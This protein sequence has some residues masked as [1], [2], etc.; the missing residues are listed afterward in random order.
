M[1]WLFGSAAACAHAKLWYPPKVP[2]HSYALRVRARNTVGESGFPSDADATSVFRAAA[3]AP[4]PPIVS[5]ATGL[6]SSAV[7]VH[8]S[9]EG[10][11]CHGEHPSKFRIECGEGEVDMVAGTSMGITFN[12]VGNLCVD[13][14]CVRLP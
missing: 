5:R 8:V 13:G 3:A 1:C 9:T 6:S 2:G 11:D 12:Q 10:I 7:K 14:V 4:D